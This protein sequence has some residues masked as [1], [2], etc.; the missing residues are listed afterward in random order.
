M[1]QIRGTKFGDRQASRALAAPIWE[2]LLTPEK[3][4]ILKLLIERI[5][6]D[7]C[8]LAVRFQT[9]PAEAS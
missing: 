2:V 5:D 4:R 1:D 7:G 6:Y 9:L 3:E 8:R